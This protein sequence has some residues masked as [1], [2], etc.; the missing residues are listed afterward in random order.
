M[1]ASE[2]F[3]GSLLI[4]LERNAFNRSY[5][6]TEGHVPIGFATDRSNVFPVRSTHLVHRYFHPR[7]TNKDRGRQFASTAYI[8]Y[9]I[10]V[11][12]F[13][14][15]LLHNSLGLLVNY[16][17]S[18]WVSNQINPCAVKCLPLVLNVCMCA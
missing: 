9:A 3:W 1:L 17:D 2:Y 7:I 6:G 4:K 16:K 14:M 10:F 12:R 18:Y 11:F 15:G 13:Q 8:F 5:K